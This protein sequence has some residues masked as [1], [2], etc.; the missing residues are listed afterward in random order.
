MRSRVVHR[1]EPLHSEDT[2]R[3]DAI[4]HHV[5]AAEVRRLEGELARSAKYQAT[6]ESVIGQLTCILQF[7]TL[8][9]AKPVSS[10]C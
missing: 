8:P 4:G 9:E 2:A 5:L 1:P 10:E 7:R 6:L 3:S